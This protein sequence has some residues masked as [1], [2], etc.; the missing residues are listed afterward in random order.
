MNDFQCAVLNLIRDR[1]PQGLAFW[2]KGPDLASIREAPLEAHADIVYSLHLLNARHIINESAAKAFASELAK[3]ALYCR[4]RHYQAF[5]ETPNAHLTAYALGAMRLLDASGIAS[6]PAEISSGWEIANLVSKEMLPI[7]PRAWSHHVWRVSHWIG[8]IPSILLQLSRLGHDV[9]DDAFVT[10]VLK[11]CEERII[12][13]DTG[14]LRPYKS[15]LIQQAFRAAYKLRHEP[16]LADIGGVVHLL[17]IYHVLDR[18]YLA[19][20]ALS[21]AAVR[22]MQRRPFIESAPYCLDFDIVQLAR[23]T[24][25]RS[26]THQGFQDR[27]ASLYS[28]IRSFFMGD[29]PSS[30][31]LHKVPG[32]LATMHESA[33]ICEWDFLSEMCQPPID[34][35]RDAYWI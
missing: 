33:M 7:W 24:R 12:D 20:A 4:P 34:I 29:V 5:G 23:T 27:A 25:H 6:I 22:H 32:A 28:D 3:S 21:E 16:E 1:C 9:I 30:Y 2:E 11:T 8:G 18:P 31:N 10:T 35:I 15:E 17:W 13:P 26:V 19:D 14:L